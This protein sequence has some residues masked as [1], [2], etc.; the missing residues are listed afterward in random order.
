MH[1]LL[2]RISN[3]DSGLFHRLEITA[4]HTIE[5]MT[6]PT[7]YTFWAIMSYPWAANTPTTS[8][9]DPTYSGSK[10]LYNSYENANP[11]WDV[12]DKQPKRVHLEPRF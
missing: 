8:H 2:D 1:V 11:S 6:K 10:D 7:N 5:L 9:S 12:H 4:Q 3:S